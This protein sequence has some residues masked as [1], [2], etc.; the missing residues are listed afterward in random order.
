MP[1]VVL[2]ELTVYMYGSTAMVDLPDVLQ[3]FS[4]L[5]SHSIK[6]EP[7]VKQYPDLSCVSKKVIPF[8]LPSQLSAVLHM[9]AEERYS[10]SDG[11]A[12]LVPQNLSVACTKCKQI[13]WSDPYLE[14]NAVIITNIQLLQA[15][16]M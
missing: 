9:S 11:V 16:G 12:Q 8:D 4:T 14:R 2:A 1:P 15:Q 7:P 6:I 13:S 5:V 10:I 3:E